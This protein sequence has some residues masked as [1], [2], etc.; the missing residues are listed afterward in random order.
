MCVFW[1]DC[2]SV[3]EKKKMYLCLLRLKF[4]DVVMEYFYNIKGRRK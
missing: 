4:F 1:G 2:A 3:V